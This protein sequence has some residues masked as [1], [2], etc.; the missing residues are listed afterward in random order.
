MQQ[1]NGHKNECTGSGSLMVD[2]PQTELHKDQLQPMKWNGNGLTL[3]VRGT[4][5][6]TRMSAGHKS[7]GDQN[8]SRHLQ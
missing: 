2:G 5:N 6:Q 1:L 8:C 4:I 3:G 7:T